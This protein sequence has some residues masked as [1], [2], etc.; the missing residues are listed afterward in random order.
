MIKIEALELG[1]LLVCSVRYSIGRKSY[2]PSIVADNVRRHWRDL[3][4]GARQAI[5]QD[6]ADA[7]RDHEAGYRSLGWDCDQKTWRDL[8][9]FMSGGE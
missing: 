6:V 7:I 5:R 4:N 1:T 2:M 9:A 3:E 8:A